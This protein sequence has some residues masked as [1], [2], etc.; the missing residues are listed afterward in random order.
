MQPEQEEEAAAG[1]NATAEWVHYEGA[2]RSASARGASVGLVGAAEGGRFEEATPDATGEDGPWF[3]DPAEELEE[4]EATDSQRGA[5]EERRSS[6]S[7]DHPWFFDPSAEHDATDASTSVPVR[8]NSH[9]LKSPADDPGAAL[10]ARWLQSDSPAV[11]WSA[12]EAIQV[13]VRKG[14]K[15][16]PGAV[17]AISANL[18]HPDADVRHASLM[19]VSR[20]AERGDDEAVALLAPCLD[21][22][23]AEVRHAAVV[24][25]AMLANNGDKHIL[26]RLQPLLEDDADYVAR[27]ARAACA[28]LGSV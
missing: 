27:A 12:L 6:R 2:R 8:A 17:R 28:A 1:P 5:A 14:R 26:G 23:D 24:A 21:D 15:G 22:A 9:R 25:I 7:Q 20:L 16:N 18:E 4:V 3:F 13:L 19:T 10:A 11:R